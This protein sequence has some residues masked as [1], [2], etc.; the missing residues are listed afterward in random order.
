M[1]KKEYLWKNGEQNKI[2]RI[3]KTLKFLFGTLKWNVR[4]N[5]TLNQMKWI[6]RS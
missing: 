6:Y 5:W 4:K 1:Q 3:F 2:L